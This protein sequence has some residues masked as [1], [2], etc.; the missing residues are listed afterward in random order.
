MIKLPS[1]VVKFSADS[2]NAQAG[3]YAKFQDYF[4]HYMSEVEKKRIGSFDDT[5]SLAAKDKEIHKDFVNEVERMANVKFSQ[6]NEGQLLMNPMVQYA[7]FGIV[8]SMID[9]ILPLTIIDS[10]GLYTETRHIGFG[11]SAHFTVKPR[12]LFTVSQTGN[13]QRTAF[14]QKQFSADKTIVPVNHAVTVQVALYKVLAGKESLAEFARKAVIS[15]ETEMTKDA[16]GAFR[17][18][19]TAATMP[20]A[21][22]ATGYTQADLI[23]ICERVTAYNQGAKAVIVGT[24]SA[25]A[26]ILPNGADGHRFVSPADDIRI[27]VIRNFFGYDII[28]LPQ[29]ATG[30]YSTFDMALN[31]NEIY[32]I[33]PSSDKL[34]KCVIEG[35]TLTNSNDFYDNA[36]LTQNATFNQRWGCEFISN[37]I[38]GIVTLQ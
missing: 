16:Y 29:V 12:S 10:I 8:S 18:G 5:I 7:T 20:D 11:D 22:K 9:A 26:N 1:N 27:Q 31:D 32:V 3:I 38:A 33:A 17:A 14:I 36:N 28:E 6:L 37:A 34:I 15:I 19:L 23:K 21:L 4:C 35:T 25:L 2:G 24:N 30:D 13:A